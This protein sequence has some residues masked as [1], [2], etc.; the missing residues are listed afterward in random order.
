MRLI[1]IVIGLLIRNDAGIGGDYSTQRYTITDTITKD[2]TSPGA[3]LRTFWTIYLNNDKPAR[4]L[5]SENAISI[6][7]VS[8]HDRFHF[9]FSTELNPKIRLQ[10]TADGELRYYHHYLPLLGDTLQRNSYFNNNL[11]LGVGSRFLNNLTVTI[12]ENIELHHY[13]SSDTFTYNYFI[14]RAGVI[15]NLNIGELSLITLNYNYNRLWAQ[16]QSEQNYAENKFNLDLDNYLGTDLHLTFSD[17]FTRRSYANRLRSYWE[18]EPQFSCG[19]DFS[20]Q[21]GLKVDENLRLTWFDETTAVYQNQAENRIGLGLEFRPG[22]IL[23]FS[24]G[25]QFDVSRSLAH[26]TDQDYREL[27][28]YLGADLFKSDW[29]WLSI[30]DRFGERRYLFSDSGFQSDYRFNEFSLFGNWKIIPTSRGGFNLEVMVSIAP[31]WHQEAVDN[32]A[33]TYCLLELKYSW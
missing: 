17:Y 22:S 5:Q 16:N 8:I 33:A 27:A 31:E 24:L 25:P 12:Q 7:N 30:E 32:L 9:G 2:T 3:E 4:N 21:I 14:N 23:T 29:V 11:K 6:S 15:A 28:L 1:L 26:P 18:V 19:W 10:A 13:L 20:P